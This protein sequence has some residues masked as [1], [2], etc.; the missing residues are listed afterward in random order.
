[1]GVTLVNAVSPVFFT[2]ISDCDSKCGLI[3]NKIDG[4]EVKSDDTYKTL[5]KVL[6]AQVKVTKNL[7]AWE[8]S[9]KAMLTSK[10][11]GAI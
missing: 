9:A 10:E 4:L 5:N 11:A 1:M 7:R 2:T 6:D 3:G 8:K